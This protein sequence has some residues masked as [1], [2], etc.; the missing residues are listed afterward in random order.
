MSV[1]MAY[2]TKD[3]IYLGADNRLSE[4][5]GTPIEDKNKKLVVVNKHLAI[6]FSGNAGTQYFFEKFIK[7]SKGFKRLKIKKFKI[8]DILFY[9]ETMFMSFK[10]DIDREYA[11][12]I[13]NSSSYFII[14]GKNKENKNSIVAVSYVNGQLKNTTTEKIL[15]P[16]LG[17]DMQTCSNIFIRN[18]NVNS[19]NCI[20]KSIKE[21][22]E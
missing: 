17:L 12:N 9:I 15:F 6:A 13:L 4:K 22:S 5:D 20:P 7:E 10:L 14:V 19:N 21:I 3:K 8:E 11:R 16:P 1:I 18:L 2:K